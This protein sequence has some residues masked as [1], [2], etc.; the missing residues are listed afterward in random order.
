MREY[1]KNNPSRDQE[2][3]V[4]FRDHFMERNRLEFEVYQY[5]L[6]KFHTIEN[7]G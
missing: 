6:L 2:V 1:D 3:P 7:D 4:G 5:C